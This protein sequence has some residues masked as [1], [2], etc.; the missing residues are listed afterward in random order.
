MHITAQ[1][2]RLRNDLYCAEW[3]V[4]LYYTLPYLQYFGVVCWPTEMTDASVRPVKNWLSVL[5]WWWWF[6]RSFAVPVVTTALPPSSLVA[7]RSRM[8][9][10]SDKPIYQ[11][12]LETGCLNECVC[13]FST[14]LWVCTYRYH[15]SVSTCV[16]LWMYVI[17][18]DESKRLLLG[19]PDLEHLMTLRVDLE[20]ILDFTTVT[21]LR[22]YRVPGLYYSFT[23]FYRRYLLD[24]ATVCCW[25]R[26]H[27]YELWI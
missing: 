13:K 3:D 12:L 6:D 23:A 19:L 7:A 2:P 4:K 20:L 18:R 14:T 25:L 1:G 17:T 15:P 26:K 10:H 11:I 21:W 22:S 5:W 16:Y 27:C 24:G 8:V 9:W